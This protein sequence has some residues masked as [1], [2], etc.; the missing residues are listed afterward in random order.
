VTIEPFKG[1]DRRTTPI[2][3]Q[4]GDLLLGATRLGAPP[5]SGWKAAAPRICD[6]QTTGGSR[7]STSAWIEPDYFDDM[8]M[9]P[10]FVAELNPGSGSYGVT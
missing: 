10:E 6:P 7:L 5:A 8:L 4:A 2:A 3:R 1:V 9:G